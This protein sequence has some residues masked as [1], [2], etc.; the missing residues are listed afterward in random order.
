VRLELAFD[1]SWPRSESDGLSVILMP[2]A[3]G[4]P[5]LRFEVAALAPRTAI[6]GAVLVGHGVPAGYEVRRAEARAMK[7]IDGWPIELHPAVVV[8]ASG[9]ARELRVLAR[10]ELSV[11]AGVVLVR[12]ATEASYR[13]REAEV[14]RLFETARPRFSSEYPAAIAELWDVRTD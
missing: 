5:Q 1:P 4:T 13:A 7:T 2:D 10:Y 11:Y 14:M 9:A 3:H 6:D 8:D 12:A